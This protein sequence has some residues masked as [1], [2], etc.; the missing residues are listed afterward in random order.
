MNLRQ[1]WPHIRKFPEP[2]S[3]VLTWVFG[4]WFDPGAWTPARAPVMTLNYINTEI[5]QGSN[6]LQW[7]YLK[8]WYSPDQQMISFSAHGNFWDRRLSFHMMEPKCNIVGWWKLELELKPPKRLHGSSEAF[9]A[10][11][12]EPELSVCE[13][14]RRHDVEVF[15]YCIPCPCKSF[16]C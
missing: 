12:A 14:Q 9:L 4:V 7:S 1:V 6:Y 5:L 16:G 3:T 15:L 8:P 2:S 11:D 10:D 13:V